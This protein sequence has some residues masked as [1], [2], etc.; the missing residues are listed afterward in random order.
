[1]SAPQSTVASAGTP[2]STGAGLS[3]TVIVCVAVVVFSHTSVAVHVLVIVP[4]PFLTLLAVSAYTTWTV[5]SQL[6][7]AVT[8]GGVMSA[9]QSTVAS[10]GTP[11]STGA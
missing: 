2:T 4:Q 8:V 1:M 11:T 7:V 6:S 10:A 9:P 3:C 5:A